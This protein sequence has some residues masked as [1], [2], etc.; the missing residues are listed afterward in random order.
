ME[1]AFSTVMRMLKKLHLQIQLEHYFQHDEEEVLVNYSQNFLSITLK[2][3]HPNNSPPTQT[4]TKNEISSNTSNSIDVSTN[5]SQKITSHHTT[6]TLEKIERHKQ[7][8][9][10]H[11]FNKYEKQKATKNKTSFPY[12]PTYWVPLLLML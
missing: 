2:I 7:S 8:D 9:P 10:F 3:L 4:T 6:N 11:E 12:P 5:N 1:W